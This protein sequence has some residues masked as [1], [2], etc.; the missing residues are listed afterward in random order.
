[1]IVG[2]LV[3]RCPTAGRALP[4]RPTTARD[5]KMGSDTN[6]RDARVTDASDEIHIDAVARLGFVRALFPLLIDSHPQPAVLLRALKERAGRLERIVRSADAS[7]AEK[8]HAR[9]C[10]AELHV[11]LV[12]L[13]RARA[14]VERARPQKDRP[15]TRP[16]RGDPDRA[17][18]RERD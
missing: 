6:C 15:Q 4:D 13:Q 5:E 11:L 17:P 18:Q 3:R 8:A 10:L 1:M 9:E 16:V 12:R 7:A 14:L 2:R